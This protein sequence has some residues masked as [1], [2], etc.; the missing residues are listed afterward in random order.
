MRL[1]TEVSG[2]RHSN[3]LTLNIFSTC[4]WN[5]FIELRAFSP[6]K[7]SY[8]SHMV[9][10]YYHRWK[11]SKFFKNLISGILDNFIH[12]LFLQYLINTCREMNSFCNSETLPRNTFSRMYSNGLFRTVLANTFHQEHHSAETSL[13]DS[14]LSSYPHENASVRLN[15][16]MDVTILT[17]DR[18]LF[19]LST[20]TDRL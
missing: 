16:L 15:R 6:I 20:Q 2:R 17:A 13:E 19:R 14:S 5:T 3:M 8:T 10:D 1:V 11:I 9:I 4:I 7:P 18:I 12:Q